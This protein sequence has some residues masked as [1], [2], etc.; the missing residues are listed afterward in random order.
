[1]A[2]VLSGGAARRPAT[3]AAAARAGARALERAL[4]LATRTAVAV[5]VRV[6]VLGA[7]AAARR[8]VL[9]ALAARVPLARAL[10]GLRAGARVAGAAELVAQAEALGHLLD[11]AALLGAE[12]RDA[13]PG[14]PGATGAA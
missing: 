3:A 1:M 6:G 2:A 4:A 13:D 10:L 7:D 11:V 5:A 8:V 9:A 14:E 12:E